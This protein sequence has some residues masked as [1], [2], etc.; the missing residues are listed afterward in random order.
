[1]NVERDGVVASITAPSHPKR[2][3]LRIGYDEQTGDL[4]FMTKEDGRVQRVTKAFNR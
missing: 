1:L 4:F 2:A 3:H